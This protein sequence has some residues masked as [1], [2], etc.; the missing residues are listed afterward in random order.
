MGQEGNKENERQSSQQ[1]S[2]DVQASANTYRKSEIFRLIRYTI[3]INSL[4][5][6]DNNRGAKSYLGWIL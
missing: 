6:V 2:F 5:N 4:M 3:S 1:T